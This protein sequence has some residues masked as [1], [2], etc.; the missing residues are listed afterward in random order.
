MSQ[1]RVLRDLDSL[2]TKNMLNTQS[3]FSLQES[4]LDIQEQLSTVLTQ[5]SAYILAVG[6]EVYLY[7]GGVLVPFI[8]VQKDYITT[9]N[10]ILMR[11][12]PLTQDYLG[13][14]MTSYIGSYMDTY[15]NTTYKDS[16]EVGY[17]EFALPSSNQNGT[18][19]NSGSRAI[20]IP[21][22]KEL[23]GRAVTVEGREVNEG[24]RFEYFL[25]GNSVICTHNGEGVI[26]FLRTP[27]SL[28]S[29]YIVTPTGNYSF[30]PFNDEHYIRPFV[31]IAHSSNVYKKIFNDTSNTLA[32]AVVT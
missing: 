1:P 17:A 7:E 15:L 16:L 19:N 4:I 10:V 30:S 12:Y 25:S 27:Y 13:L 9:D 3:I 31:S 5:I 26:Y 18:E 23:T 2:E 32:T 29:Y 14:S 21:S 20:F 28:S 11:K 8:V 22:Y 6:D 24:Y